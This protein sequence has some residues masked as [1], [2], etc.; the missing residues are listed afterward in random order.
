MSED[1]T[2]GYKCARMFDK[3]YEYVG[4]MNQ[5]VFLCWVLTFDRP[6][7]AHKY[8]YSRVA[9]RVSIATPRFS[10]GLKAKWIV[11]FSP[12]RQHYQVAMCAVDSTLSS[13]PVTG[14]FRLIT[15]KLDG[16]PLREIKR[17]C[18]GVVDI[19]ASIIYPA[20]L[21]AFQKMLAESTQHGN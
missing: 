3:T 12:D 1:L 19:Y 14:T 11:Q 21:P 6:K 7:V 5:E 8:D 10:L 16:D 9:G 2:A 17:V 18:A 4:M 20:I 13:T 15:N